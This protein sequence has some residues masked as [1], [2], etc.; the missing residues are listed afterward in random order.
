MKSLKHVEN[1]VGDLEDKTSTDMD[2]RVLKDSLRALEKSGKSPGAA[3]A[4]VW[5][6]TIKISVTAAAAVVIVG[7]LIG[8]NLFSGSDQP[9]GEKNVTENE[10]GL[11]KASSANQIVEEFCH[12]ALFSGYRIPYITTDYNAE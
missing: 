11:D 12:R 7:I 4:D 2:Q 6:K 5:R 8:I 1:L 3:G 10:R 9:A